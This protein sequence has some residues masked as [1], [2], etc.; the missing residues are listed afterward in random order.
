MKIAIMGKIHP[1][2]LKIFNENKIESF[3]IDNFDENYLIN[4][5]A[6]VDGIV[7][8][9]AKLNSKVLSKCKKLKAVSRHGV[10][11]DNVDFEYLS[12]NNIDLM[13]TATSNAV[14][15]AEHVMTM[16][17]N[18]T[19]NINASDNLVK[20]GKF[21]KKYELPDFFELYNKTL[22]I[23]GFGR[24][25]KE[26]A[27]RCLGFDMKVCVYDPFVNDSEIKKKNCLPVSKEEGFKNADYLSIH[28]PLNT[29]TM[30]LINYEQ[31]KIFK[32]NLILVN[33]SRGGIIN[34]TALVDALKSK[35]IF[36]V[37]LDVF[38]EEPPTENHPLFKYK[39]TLLTPHNAA[40]TLECRK[41][42]S[43]E[44][45]EN[46]YNYLFDKKN[47]NKNNII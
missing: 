31:F 4:I 46:I 33:T 29:T 11:Y 34:E 27:K 38:E 21:K 22:L 7:I 18:L 40:L 35:K 19:K 39:N 37:G 5:L 13:I 26:L 23:L 16:F 6:D 9:T 45:C 43:I 41:R 30:N 8:R 14:S 20:S 12:K 15:V 36:G 10:G 25:G 47:L 17:L 42:M 28:L 3:E 32:K 44:S 2:G 24:I 1:D